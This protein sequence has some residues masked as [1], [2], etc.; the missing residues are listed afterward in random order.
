VLIFRKILFFILLLSCSG[1]AVYHLA[2]P[3][4]ISKEN[5]FIYNNKRISSEE[6]LSMV[7]E[8]L[9]GIK[10]FVFFNTLGLSRIL[11]KHPLIKSA[12]IRN[13]FLPNKEF[14]IF[15]SEEKPW[16]FLDNQVINEKFVVL[17]NFSE[18]EFNNEP[19]SIQEL[20]RE[21]KTQKSN[22]IKIQTAK[23]M[24]NKEL[25]K[26]KN[27]IEP[28]NRNFT[29]I[30]I[31]KIQ[32]VVLDN[33]DLILDNGDIKII[34]GNLNKKLSSKMKKLDNLL[35]NIQ[36]KLNEIEYLDLSLNTNEAI[37]GKRF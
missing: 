35:I 11:C 32:K 37:I 31:P 7:E 36:E 1:F 21:I 23:A 17:K 29:L 20:Y 12:K 33:N 26:I 18:L 3:S 30:D 22:I 24:N 15:I 8:E 34:F 13:K 27:I 19:S 6:I 28:I 5:I 4:E 25:K 14:H 10:S 9:G 16:A 2:K